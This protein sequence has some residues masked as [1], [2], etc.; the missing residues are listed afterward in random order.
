[1]TVLNLNQRTSGGSGTGEARPV[2]PTDIYRMKCIEAKMQDNTFE[3][4]GK[5]GTLP[6]QIVLTFEMSQLTDE[7]QEAM[8]EADEDWTSVRIWHRFAPY[9]GDVKA[10]GPSK[11]KEFLD[12]L[13]AWGLIPTL[14]EE[15]GFDLETLTTVELKCSVLRYAKTMG[16][17]AGKPGNKITGFAP[18]RAAKKGKNTPQPVTAAEVRPA[19][20]VEEEDLP[21]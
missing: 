16:E 17:N 21:F 10:G 1:M 19:A 6:Q 12:N 13:V 9:Y 5:D 11:L 20:S 14:D 8:E 3:K 2:L 18:V 7:Q 4:P 15:V